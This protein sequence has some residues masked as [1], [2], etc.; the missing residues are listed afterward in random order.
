M[1]TVV[2]LYATALLR[3]SQPHTVHLVAAT[4]DWVRRA[5]TNVC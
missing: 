4:S 1:E 5:K 2:S 3:G